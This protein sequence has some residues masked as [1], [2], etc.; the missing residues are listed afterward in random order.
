MDETVMLPA[1]IMI[2]LKSGSKKR[3]LKG[4]AIYPKR[5]GNTEKDNGTILKRIPGC[6]PICTPVNVRGHII[7]APEKLVR[8][9]ERSVP[10]A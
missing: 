5:T 8:N 7:Q 2:R 4:L 1:Q 3:T 9:R 10:D 6:F